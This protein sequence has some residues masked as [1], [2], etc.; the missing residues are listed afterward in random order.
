MKA[1][2]EVPVDDYWRVSK[3]F[4]P[5]YPNKSFVF[6]V[7]SR[8]IPGRVF[9]ADD[10][11]HSCLVTTNSPYA[12]LAG[13]FDPAIALRAL[14]H[15]SDREDVKIILPPGRVLAEGIP[16]G[17]DLVDRV[18]YARRGATPWTDTA[19]PAGFRL[20]V[21][22]ATLFRRL[23]WNVATDLFGG[24]EGFLRGGYGYCLTQ[25]GAVAAEAYSV[26]GAGISE[27]G[28]YTAPGFR[29]AGL[30]KVLLHELLRE[31]DRRGHQTVLSCDV[32]T[33]ATVALARRFEMTLDIEYQ[34]ARTPQ[35]KKTN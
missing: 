33:H 20:E 3:F 16:E 34:A 19:V 26:V 10:A 1:L 14:L 35:R 6:S 9:S 17:V 5:D 4:G 11:K 7:L 23:N 27:P 22:D 13:D 2:K 30:Q 28:I 12:F 18:Q 31:A 29:G 25:G 21:L 32:S 8:R 24:F 15:L